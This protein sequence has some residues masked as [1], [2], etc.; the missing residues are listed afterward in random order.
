MRAACPRAH[1]HAQHHGTAVSAQPHARRG[2][3][4]TRT[5]DPTAGVALRTHAAPAGTMANFDGVKEFLSK[6]H[7]GPLL[8]N[9]QGVSLTQTAA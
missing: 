2:R 1:W 4:R 6:S 9:A 7:L 3:S 8:T 5:S